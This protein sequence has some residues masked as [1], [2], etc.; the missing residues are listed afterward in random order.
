MASWLPVIFF[1]AE[2]LKESYIPFFKKEPSSYLKTKKPIR[3]GRSAFLYKV[4]KLIP[5]LKYSA[6][7]SELSIPKG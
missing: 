7:P 2:K 5:I 6:G 1:R 4:T 3:R